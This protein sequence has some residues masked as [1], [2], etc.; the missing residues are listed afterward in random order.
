MDA[1]RPNM[2]EA[3]WATSELS[4]LNADLARFFRRPQ[5]RFTLGADQ[6]L[7]DDLVICGILGGKDIGKSTLINAL[8]GTRVSVDESEVGRGT[9]RPR[10]YAHRAQGNTVLERLGDCESPKDIDLVLHD[11]EQIAN[12][13]LVDLPD[14]DS[15]FL[16]HLQVV[17]R[18]APRLD[19]VLWVQSPRK[20]GDR[21]WVQMLR[22][23]IK[24]FANV[25]L[26]LNKVDELLADG[27]FRPAAGIATELRSTGN[28]GAR[29]FWT[30]QRQWVNAAVQSSGCHLPPERVFLVAGLYPDAESF[31][32]RIAHRWDDPQW[33]R[34][35]GDRTLVQQVAELAAHDLEKLRAAVI[36]PVQLNQVRQIKTANWIAEQR[37]WASRL[38]EHFGLTRTSTLLESAVDPDYHQAT[39][40][41]AFGTPFCMHAA[42]RVAAEVRG[43]AD[44][45]DELLASRIDRWPL[46][47]LAYFPL[48]WFSRMIGRQWSLVRG[49]ASSRRGTDWELALEVDHRPLADRVS[50][51]REQLVADHGM[52][53]K[54]LGMTEELPRGERLAIQFEESVRALPVQL[55]REILDTLQIRGR[56]PSFVA[57]GFLW[58][59]FLW[60]PL[61]QPLLEGLLDMLAAGE[62]WELV[63]GMARIV[64]ALSAVHLLAG[65][66]VVAIIFS[67]LIAGMYARCL[68]DV[69]RLRQDL[70]T[71]DTISQRVDDLLLEEVAAPLIRPLVA[72]RDEVHA[73]A[74][75]LNRLHDSRHAA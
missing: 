40:N 44:L 64:A 17:Q 13:V 33:R 52:V 36:G 12:V 32:A 16:D 59:V 69:R 75:R 57:R 43:D 68:K 63:K 11:V 39:L 24:D 67:L 47:R 37:T 3:N 35:A 70:L 22:D 48:G 49:L 26:V 72:M 30:A 55:E 8:A 7:A 56:K 27:D 2:N 54:D 4:A 66:A 61:M 42:E 10:A 18:V 23:V 45:A 9:D 19:R 51:Y 20:L 50:L 41:S 31:T 58:F 28:Q 53:C 15:E 29:E 1:G 65:F 46:L 71:S 5:L 14:F 73:F 21:A 60:F 34:Y 62:S 74:D 6:A 25:H 38:D